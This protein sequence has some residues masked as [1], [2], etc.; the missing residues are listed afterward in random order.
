MARLSSL[1]VLLVLAFA[2]A[3][4]SAQ[5]PVLA[6]ETNMTSQSSGW[7][8]VSLPEP[9]RVFPD[10]ENLNAAIAKLRVL[11]PGRLR[12]ALLRAERPNLPENKRAEWWAFSDHESTGVSGNS[13]VL[14]PGDY[15][16]HLFLDQAPATLE[17][18]AP[19]L[20]GTA[21]L[22]TAVAQP[23]TTAPLPL[24][25]GQRPQTSVFGAANDFPSSG[26]VLLD[27][28]YATATTSVTRAEFCVYPSGEPAADPY[29]P[30][31]PGGSS[32]EDPFFNY[33]AGSAERG[34]QITLGV[35]P[36]RPGVG[37]N[38]T[39]GG[40]PPAVDAFAAWLPDDPAGLQPP[41]LTPGAPSGGPQAQPEQEPEPDWKQRGRTLPAIAIARRLAV[42]RGRVSLPLRC[43]TRR[44]CALHAQLLPGGPPRRVRLATGRATRLSLPLGRKLA[45]RLARRGTATATL[46]LQGRDEYG[47]LRMLDRRVRLR[48]AA[49]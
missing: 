35:K 44:E 18:R 14:P 11:G 3:P 45:R 22:T 42:R 12:A 29:E 8:P 9:M 19:S 6:E 4:A 33:T 38:F 7:T 36:G 46:R 26:K 39:Y 10:E 49:S 21:A 16:L 27:V 25:P 48:A 37:G 15:R 17:L 41:P 1:A 47:A 28:D 40:D 13:D 43:G 2:A 30:R 23:V 24:R 5:R 34:I 31:C 32:F 20:G